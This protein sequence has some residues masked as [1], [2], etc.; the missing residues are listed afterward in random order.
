MENINSVIA[1]NKK[2]IDRLAMAEKQL[3]HAIHILSPEHA[4]SAD[5]N[6]PEPP[7]SDLTSPRAPI[8]LVDRLVNTK[9]EYDGLSESI[10]T[11]VNDLTELLD[12]SRRDTAEVRACDV[13]D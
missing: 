11:L 1:S 6:I 12:E 10:W 8:G 13:R 5:G 7:T 2:I 3:K 9:D 4:S